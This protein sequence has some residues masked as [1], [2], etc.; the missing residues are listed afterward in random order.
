M[1]RWGTS[2][3]GRVRR[4]N[5][6]ISAATEPAG[7]RSDSANP[8]PR[9][10]AS[11]RVSRRQRSVWWALGFSVPTL[12]G[13]GA[14][15]WGIVIAHALAY[16]VGTVAAPNTIAAVDG[17]RYRLAFVVGVIATLASASSMAWLAARTPARTWSPLAQGL[18]AALFAAVAGASALL[19]TLGMNPIGFVGALWG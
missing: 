14:L 16:G 11:G 2:R 18:A 17:D 5:E 1:R 7:R 19:M 13:L 8:G 3:F 15:T 4:V 6:S 12:V 10:W 9:G